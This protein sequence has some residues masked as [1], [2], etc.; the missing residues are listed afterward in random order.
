MRAP[1]AEG[2]LVTY[3]ILT[4]DRHGRLQLGE[5]FECEGDEAA[6][7]RLHAFERGGL[8]AELWQGGRL[9]IR[10]DGDGVTR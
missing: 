1:H 9:V 6:L 8:A 7:D 3:R 10:L 2:L 4:I 5:S